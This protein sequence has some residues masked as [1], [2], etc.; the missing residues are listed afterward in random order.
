[1]TTGQAVTPRPAFV[2]FADA[3]ELAALR[4][5]YETVPARQAVMLS[6]ACDAVRRFVKRSARPN[7]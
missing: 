6:S 3:E 1:M 2:D 7:A 5:W 4:S